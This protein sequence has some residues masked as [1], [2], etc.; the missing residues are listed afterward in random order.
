MP[1]QQNLRSE[2]VQDILTRV[3]HW[4]VQWGNGMILALLVLFFILAWFIK[5]P[6]IIF[7]ESSVTSQR[8]PQKELARYSGMIDT[9]LVQDEQKVSPGDM[10]AVI[11]NSANLKDVLLLKHILDTLSVER[12]KFNF[13]IEELPLLNLGDI[14]SSFAL[15]ETEYINYKLNNTLD[16]FSGSMTANRLSVSEIRMRIDNLDNQKKLDAKSLEFSKNELERNKVLYEKGVISLQEYE[17]KE[18]SYL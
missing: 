14:N 13:P 8:P 12:N 6:D 5:Y 4:M 9:I 17:G 3:P 2:E 18:I 16:P 11:D 7:S 15:F 1:Q 10:L